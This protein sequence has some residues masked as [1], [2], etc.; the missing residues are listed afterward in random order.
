MD[1]A[2]TDPRVELFDVDRVGRRALEDY[3][4]L[5]LATAADWSDEPA[6]DFETA[7]A[8]LRNPVSVFGP[9]MRW[10]AYLDDRVVGSQTLYLPGHESAHLGVLQVT[11][12]PDVRRRG[13]GGLLLDSALAELRGRGRT[14]VEG[15]NVPQ[16]GAGEQ[17]AAAMGFR[18]V[19]VTV[20]QRLLFDEV[21]PATW[22]VPA[23]A[24]YRV[25]AWIDEAPA[26]LVASYARAR[27]AIHD[28]PL[29]A[30]GYR[31]PDWTV[32]RVRELEA[33]RRGTGMRQWVVAAVHEADGEVAGITELELRSHRDDRAVQ[34]D[35]AVLAGHRGH[36]LGRYIKAHMVR[37]LRADLPTV[38]RVLTSTA[39]S[40]T[41]M[42]RVNHQ[43]GFT[44]ARPAMVCN[45]EVAD[46]A[47]RR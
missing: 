26:D 45:G 22:D 9:S 20:S 24:G 40:N 2:G 43:I 25:V 1:R 3:H 7:I 47:A 10:A 17:W 16:G 15:W 37:W 23:P 6:A 8:A 46:L 31:L 11:V 4:R 19:H 5:R 13:V 36:G 42:I 44:T 39:A 28:A 18:T 27:G 35:T 33:E 34:G 41:H 12:H 30:A 29:G 21:D 32:Q 38:R 14:L